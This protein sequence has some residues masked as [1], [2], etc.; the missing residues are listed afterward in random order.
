M[1]LSEKHSLRDKFTVIPLNNFQLGNG[2][3]TKVYGKTLPIVQKNPISASSKWLHSF[4]SCVVL[5]K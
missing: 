5:S 1:Q 2:P 4:R 3:K